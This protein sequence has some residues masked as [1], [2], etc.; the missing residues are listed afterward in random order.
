MVTENEIF[1]SFVIFPLICSSASSNGISGPCNCNNKPGEEQAMGAITEGKRPLGPEL[2]H[3]SHATR[4]RFMTLI[5][6]KGMDSWTQF[7][8]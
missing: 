2:Q 4:T 5:T 8:W 6:L 3:C 7:M 1:E